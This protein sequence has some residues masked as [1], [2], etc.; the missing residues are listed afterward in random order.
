MD[1][2]LSGEF[3]I[4]IPLS[5]G[6]KAAIGHESA[7]HAKKTL[8]VMTSPDG[9]SDASIQMS[10]EKAQQWINAVRNGHLHH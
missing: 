9:N 6:G 8:G 4:T 5:G 2:A 10:Q 7:N 1:N 3:G